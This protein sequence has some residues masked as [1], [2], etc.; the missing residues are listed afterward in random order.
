MIIRINQTLK[1]LWQDGYFEEYRSNVD[2]ETKLKTDFGITSSNIRSH[3]S[4]CQ[5]FLR[6]EPKGWIQ[7][8]RYSLTEPEKLEKNYFELLNIHQEIRKV[9]ERLFNN[10]H[11]SQAISEAYKKIVNMVKDKTNRP[12]EN[13]KELDGKDL[14]FK[15]FNKQNPILKLNNLITESD[16]N[17][18]EGF[19]YLYAGAVQGIRNPKAH[20]NIEQN[21]IIRTLEYLVFASLLAKR[22]NESKI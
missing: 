2:I 3:L 9:S 17:E 13:E 6:K 21:D 14:M 12:K 20:D 15:V 8:F 22:I 16:V 4:S 5:K 11:Y 18:Q 19:M 10:R 7:K 1:I